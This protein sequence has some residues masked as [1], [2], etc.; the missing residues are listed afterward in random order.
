MANRRDEYGRKPLPKDGK[1][2]DYYDWSNDKWAVRTK[3]EKEQESLVDERMR[4]A[5][6]RKQKVFREREERKKKDPTRD[7]F[8]RKPKPKD[9]KT[10]DWDHDKDKWVVRKKKTQEILDS[11]RRKEEIAREWMRRKG[12]RDEYGRKPIPMDGKKYDHYDFK[13]D[14]WVEKKKRR[15]KF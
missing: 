10:Y 13:N 12:I 1:K 9:G 3:R 6:E 15:V 14:K 2:Y 11:L 5:R 4:K 8:G 7:F